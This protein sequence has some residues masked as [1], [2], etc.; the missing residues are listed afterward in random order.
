[1][2]YVI[3]GKY[4]VNVSP[5]IYSEVIV[6]AKGTVKPAGKKIEVKSGTYVEMIKIADVLKRNVK[7]ETPQNSER[8]INQKYNRRRK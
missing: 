3:D 8:S 5:S 6:D 7:I 1:M 4:Y 2:L